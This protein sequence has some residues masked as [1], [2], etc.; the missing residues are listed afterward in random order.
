MTGNTLAKNAA[1]A[2]LAY[3][4]PLLAGVFA[5]PVLIRDLGVERFGL[6]S[7]AWMYVGYFSLFDLGIGRALARQLSA[8]STMHGNAELG[9]VVGSGLAGLAALGAAAAAAAAA[10]SPWLTDS[11]LRVPAPLRL[12]ALQLFLVLAASLLIV[13][14]SAGLEGVLQSFQRFDAIAWIRIPL[15]LWTFLGPLLA[16]RI[17]PD[18]AMV[19]V[20]IL[21]GRVVGG[22]AYLAFV[23]DALRSRNARPAFSR[24]ALKS[25]LAFGGWVTVSNVVGP[26]MVYLDR[27]VIGVAL[28]LAAVTFY[29]A[30]YDVITRLGF[31]GQAVGAVLLPGLAAAHFSK[32]EQAARLIAAG[33]VVTYVLLFPFVAGAVLLASPA[34]ELW[35]GP[36]FARESA[37]VLRI[38]AIGVFLNGL[39]QVALAAV[40]GSG[41]ARWT[42]TLHL[43]EAP[44]YFAALGVAVA[45]WGVNGAALAWTLRVALDAAVL[46]A[47][48]ARLYRLP[49]RLIGTLALAVAAGLAVIGVALATRPF[50]L[51]LAIGAGAS[52]AVATL[53]WIKGR[54]LMRAET[55]SS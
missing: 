6:V 50:W 41:H 44:V 30:P 38:L 51:Q 29:S 54:R 8:R 10:L 52:V 1:W 36:T 28:S 4:L 46:F 14:P 53:V 21:A 23:Q 35:L 55:P 49:A 48:T 13:I 15:G 24:A 18:A 32:P 16:V 3:G 19:G 26:L 34:L 2:L 37:G 42:A 9:V 17:E 20:A 27:F 12:E 43:V 11:L 39:A 7:L 25:L 47:M 40:Q 5:I 45:T 33:A 22:L 31:I